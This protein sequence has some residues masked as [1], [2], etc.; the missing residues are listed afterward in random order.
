MAIFYQVTTTAK[1]S[2][3]VS[4]FENWASRLFCELVYSSPT[5]ESDWYEARLIELEWRTGSLLNN[6][7][8]PVPLPA[9]KKLHGAPL[10]AQLVYRLSEL[11]WPR[12]V[13][14]LDRAGVLSSTYCYCWAS[15]TPRDLLDAPF[16]TTPL[17]LCIYQQA[18]CYIV[19]R[20]GVVVVFRWHGPVLGHKPG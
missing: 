16:R 15:I 2:C 1:I 5:L 17:K 3:R 10:L 20:W 6:C 19:Y 14:L 7:L 18:Y 12:C 11:T 4:E 13:N 8:D 9:G